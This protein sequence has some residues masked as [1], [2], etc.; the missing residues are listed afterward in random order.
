MLQNPLQV[1]V[2]PD[3]ASVL[4]VLER[5]GQPIS[6]RTIAALTGTVSQPTVSR[7]L[8]DLVDKGVVMQVPGGYVL[9]REHLAYRAIE[10]MLDA[11]EELRRRI[12]STV[13]SWITPPDS[14]VLFGSTA[15]GRSTPSSDVDLLVVRPRTM[16]TDDSAWAEDVATLA[17][18]VT[19]WTGAPCDVLEYDPPE[20]RRLA[21]A[22]DPL[23]DSLLRDGITLTGRDL[24]ELLTEVE[25]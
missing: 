21:A 14:V 19:T 7:I 16:P 18:Q 6:G 24:S 17:E 22:A 9:N 13:A 3:T 15:R 5:A 23:I 2:S 1:I 8:R 4:V 11:G 25:R 20:L 10:A 12:E